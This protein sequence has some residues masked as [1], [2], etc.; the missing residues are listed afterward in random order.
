MG[1][2][3]SLRFWCFFL[4]FSLTVFPFLPDYF[5]GGRLRLLTGICLFQ[6]KVIDYFM[7]CSLNEKKKKTKKKHRSPALRLSQSGAV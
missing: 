6:T 5:L 3:I 4:F 7:L 2:V 1:G